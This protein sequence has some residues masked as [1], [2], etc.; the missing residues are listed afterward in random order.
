MKLIIAFRSFFT[1]ACK[2]HS[3]NA[4]YG[5]NQCLLLKS[6]DARKNCMVEYMDKCVV[7]YVAAGGIC[8]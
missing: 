2:N 3:V 8:S 5:N 7:F 6:H 4:I 1:N